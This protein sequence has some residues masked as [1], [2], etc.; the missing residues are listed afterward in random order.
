MEQDV[1]HRFERTSC[2]CELC[3]VPCR[4]M[5]GAMIPGDLE[6]ISDH[7]G[8]HMSGPWV[9]EH[10]RASEGPRVRYQGVW[11]SVAPSM[12][13]AQKEDGS[14]VFLDDDGRCEVHPV[15]PFGCAYM[16]M[17]MGKEEADARSMAMMGEQVEDAQSE[18]GFYTTCIRVLA[19]KGLVA[20]PLR[21]RRENFHREL[22]TVEEE[23][24][25][26]EQGDV[27]VA[28]E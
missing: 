25:N 19:G 13:P 21:E 8:V 16:D 3:K 26:G 12:V 1:R 17:H 2:D 18:D 6:A 20:P 11:F 27:V 4:H 7:L 9:E 22:K 15:A 24:T 23:K 14:C 28:A 10:F 5:P